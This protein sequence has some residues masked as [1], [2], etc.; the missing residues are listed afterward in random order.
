MTEAGIHIRAKQN[1]AALIELRYYDASG[2]LRV[3]GGPAEG[4]CS[5]SGFAATRP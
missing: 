5:L 2:R 1:T 4:S 3:V